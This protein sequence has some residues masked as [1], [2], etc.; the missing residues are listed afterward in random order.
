MKPPNKYLKLDQVIDVLLNDSDDESND[1]KE[2]DDDD[3]ELEKNMP[4]NNKPLNITNNETKNN[5]KVEALKKA[6]SEDS[7][8]SE[9]DDLPLSKLIIKKGLSY[10]MDTLKKM[11]D[12]NATRRVPSRQQSTVRLIKHSSIKR[13]KQQLELNFLKGIFDFDTL[14]DTLRVDD[15]NISL[16]Y[17]DMDES[18]DREDNFDENNSSSDSINYEYQENDKE[19]RQ[20]NCNKS[21]VLIL[22]NSSS[23]FLL[24]KNPKRKF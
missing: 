19:N 4:M 1:F 24:T 11:E 18:D 23:N 10:Q 22:Q 2:D 3:Q 14:N 7:D 15:P 9:D 21:P 6:E 20:S 13:E 17:S 12:P 8:D 16:V 5:P